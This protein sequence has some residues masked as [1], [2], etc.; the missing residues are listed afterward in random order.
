MRRENADPVAGLISRINDIRLKVDDR[1]ETR[2]RLRGAR[3]LL[4]QA[5]SRTTRRENPP[6][7]EH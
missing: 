1:E 7:A 5:L 6:R 4:A 2:V 3:I